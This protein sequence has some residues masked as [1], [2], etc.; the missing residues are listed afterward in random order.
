[1]SDVMR[2]PDLVSGCARYYKVDTQDAAHALHELIKELCLEYSV[3]QGKVALP[4]HIFWVGRVGSSQRSIRSYKLFF[5]GLIKYLD[6]S[7]DPLSGV[8]KD[9]IPSY[10]ESDSSAKDIPAGLIYLS[11]S[12]LAKWALDAGVEPPDY[13]LNVNAGE[14]AKGGEGGQGFQ[15]KEL[16][17][18]NKIINGLVD[19]IKEV[20]KAH[21]GRLLG[22]ADKMRAEAIKRAASRLNNPPRKNFDLYS[23]V[24]SLAEDAGVDMPKDHKTLRKYMRAP[25]KSDSGHEV[26]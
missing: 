18:I 23:A 7:C 20:D 1:M 2:L 24:I 12:A 3:R 22:S 16:G 5:D 9:L 4:G 6:C 26:T 19:L 14:S 17:T 25:S 10:C 8:D 15:E 21:S 13:I 11:K